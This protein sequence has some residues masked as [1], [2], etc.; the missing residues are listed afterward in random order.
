MSKLF[1]RIWWNL[2]GW[3]LNGEI[4]SGLKKMILLVGPHTSWK[5]ILLGL[6]TRSKLKIYKAKFLGKKE[7][8]DGPFGWFFRWL[9]GVP[10][11]RKSKHGMVEQVVD[12]FNKSEEFKL[13]LSPEGTR[14]KVD[15]LR[16]GFYNIAKQ[17]NVPIVMVGFDFSK[18]EVVLGDAFYT[19]NNE[20]GDF[21]KIIDFFAP[22]KVYHPQIVL[23]HLKKN[24]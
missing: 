18:K 19:S 5:D 15:K 10:V 17:A 9:G 21:K 6:A 1:W 13:G 22:I 20:E 11:D 8:F 3:K 24:N 14:K 16:T 12:M 7:L 4:P 23:E 2:N